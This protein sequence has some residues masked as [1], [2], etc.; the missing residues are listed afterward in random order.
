MI[1]TVDR[2]NFAGARI[3]ASL[4][5]A[6]L[7]LVLLAGCAGSRGDTVAYNR[8]DFVPPDA[9]A[10]ALVEADHKLQP[11]D[12]VTINVFQVPDVS[13]DREVDGL[14]RI[15]LPLIGMVDAQ[16]LTTTELSTRLATRL[17][18]SY[19]RDPR[20][21]VVIKTV[22][23]QTITVDGSVNQPGVYPIPARFSLIQAVALARGPSEDA[24]VK[25]VV[26]F[27]R[28]NGQRQAA[29]FDLST[30]RDG[31]DPDPEVFGDDVIVV[32]GS[33][34]RQ[35]FRD[36]LQTVPLLSVFRPF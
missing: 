25:Q 21:Q 36:I 18:E 14:G 31:T 10:T 19:L 24:N 22:R 32:D 8:S 5:M 26:V 12:I 6:M 3:A 28:I 35:T 2:R 7:A 4:L 23:Q 17:N 30:I 9:N 29:A 16:G 27:R 33:A 11:G 20:V 1:A 13:G 15:Q 34:T